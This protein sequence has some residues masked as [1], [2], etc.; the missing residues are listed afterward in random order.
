MPLAAN[1]MD[2]NLWNSSRAP[3]G[4]GDM[5]SGSYG[6]HGLY[7]DYGRG[8]SYQLP[9][10]PQIPAMAG[11]YREND[12]G[13]E[14]YMAPTVSSSARKATPPKTKG[15][16]TRRKRGDRS[17]DLYYGAPYGAPFGVPAFPAPMYAAPSFVGSVSSRGAYY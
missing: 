4:I 1:A 12:R 16:Q 17:P 13:D 8:P 14:G 7:P 11:Y 10:P 9:Y 3:M 2:A 6:H 5:H 15:G